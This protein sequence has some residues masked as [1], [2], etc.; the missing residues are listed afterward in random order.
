M[1]SLVVRGLESPKHCRLMKEIGFNFNLTEGGFD[2]V[3]PGK[4]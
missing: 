2:N 3:T 1:E 4:S